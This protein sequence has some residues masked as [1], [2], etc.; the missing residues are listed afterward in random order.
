MGIAAAFFVAAPL[1][2]SP[3]HAQDRRD[4][5]EHERERYQTPHWVFDDRFRHNHYY[6]SA[7]YTLSVLPPANIAVTFGGARLF[8]QA[9]VWFQQAGPG[10]VVVRPPVGIVVPVLPPAHATVWVG[11]VPHYY[12][13]DVYYTETLGGYVVTAPPMEATPAPAQ[14]SPPPAPAPAASAPPASASWYYCETSK[15]Y[16][17]YI[18]E[19][20]E[21]WK[22]V[23]ST[24]PQA[25]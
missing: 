18:S 23:P 25:R 10:Y 20:K 5:R 22:A 8:F 1:W 11:G 12:A 7:G 14:I 15:G 24:P 19:C 17:P 2:V 16:Y 3:A 13:N 6:P 21:G 9:G 4:R